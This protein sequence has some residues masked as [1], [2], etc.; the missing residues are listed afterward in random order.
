MFAFKVGDLDGWLVKQRDYCWLPLIVVD[1]DI[2]DH[3]WHNGLSTTVADND[4]VIA[5]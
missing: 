1:I 3:C 2:V 5:C 4:Y